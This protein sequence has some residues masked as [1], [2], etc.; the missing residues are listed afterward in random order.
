MVVGGGVLCVHIGLAW[1][2]W[3]V[4]VVDLVAILIVAFLRRVHLDFE[5]NVKLTSSFLFHIVIRTIRLFRCV[6]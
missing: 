3:G 5:H 1:V 4:E 2:W 6:L